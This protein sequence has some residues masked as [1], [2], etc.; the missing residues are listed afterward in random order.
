MFVLTQN[1]VTVTTAGG[2]RIRGRELQATTLKAFQH[3]VKACRAFCETTKTADGK[4]PP[5][6]RE[7]EAQ[8]HMTAPWGATPDESFANCIRYP[9]PSPVAALIIIDEKTGEEAARITPSFWYVEGR[10]AERGYSHVTFNRR[11][12]TNYR[13][14]YTYWTGVRFTLSTEVKGA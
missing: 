5:T 7:E 14:E 4:E 8:G 11:L 10:T 13:G 9:I 3:A 6:S 1:G 12:L 2:R